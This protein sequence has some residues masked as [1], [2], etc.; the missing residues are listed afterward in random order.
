M[1][2]KNLKGMKKGYK[3]GDN[4]LKLLE[5]L[6]HNRPEEYNAIIKPNT[7]IPKRRS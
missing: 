7:K 3:K 5:F 4:K 1:E 2:E 6:K